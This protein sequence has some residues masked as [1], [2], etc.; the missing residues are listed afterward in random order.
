MWNG[1]SVDC[2]NY[3]EATATTTLWESILIFLGSIIY[4]RV[5]GKR[6]ATHYKFSTMPDK[7]EKKR[8]KQIMD[9]FKKKADQEFESSLPTSR[10][11]FK[12]LFDYLD[13]QLGDKGCNDT[14]G[15]TRTF[16]VQSNVEN[17]DEVL[18]WLAEH[19]GYCDC[20][21]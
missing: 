12:K 21:I 17:A 7:S 3:N 6:K 13:T 11:N 9:D 8:R 2:Y 14:N 20:E 10:E 4:L 18:E 5:G 15:L 16:L 1:S 19:G